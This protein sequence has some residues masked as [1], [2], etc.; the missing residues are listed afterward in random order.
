[1]VQLF[2]KMR[3]L[4]FL[5][6]TVKP[7]QETKE[8]ISVPVFNAV[9]MALLTQYG[10]CKQYAGPALCLLFVADT[11]GCI[12]NEDEELMR[13]TK[14][15]YDAVFL[16]GDHFYNDLWNIVNIVPEDIP[17]YGILGNHN[18]AALYKE[19]NKQSP[20]NIIQLDNGVH[21]L[22]GIRI[23]V[24]TGSSKYKESADRI[25]FSQDE[26]KNIMQQYPHADIV[27]SHDGPAPSQYRNQAHYGFEAITE[28]IYKEHIPYCIHGHNHT[29]YRRKLAND[30]MDICVYQSQLITLA[31]V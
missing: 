13:N 26:M 6:Q 2:N 21:E 24:F 27:F 15:Q 25:M 10:S 22:L 4:L 7:V 18:T 19:F 8:N 30:A 14:R 23:A 20:R 1:M 17:V 31:P 5:P 28:Y 16:L 3:E 11:H 29:D 9:E 12:R